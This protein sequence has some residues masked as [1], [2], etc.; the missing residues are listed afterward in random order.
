MSVPTFILVH[1]HGVFDAGR[2]LIGSMAYKSICHSKFS[3]LG[4]QNYV[5]TEAC[6]IL[7]NRSGAAD[8]G[9]RPRGS[10]ACS[11]RCC[12]PSTWPSHIY[13]CWYAHVSV[14][15]CLH[16]WQFPICHMLNRASVVQRLST[17]SVWQ[18][19]ACCAVI[20]AQSLS[21][22]LIYASWYSSFSG[23]EQPFDRQ[24]VLC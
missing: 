20:E 9:R 2:R 19:P 11:L 7:I 17:W 10:T 16:V 1:L 21:R 15:R 4:I 3:M 6:C 5:F 18:M 12:T 22:A 13:S 14:T 8:A 23:T 24:P